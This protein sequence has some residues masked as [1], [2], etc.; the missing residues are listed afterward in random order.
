VRVTVVSE[1]Y[2]TEPVGKVDQPDFVN[3]TA[4]VE[5]GLSARR[6]LGICK[7]VE[8]AM[9]RGTGERWGPRV[10]DIDLL[11]LGEQIVEETDL[12]LPHPRMHERRFVLE[13]LADIAPDVVHPRLG[14]TVRGLLRRL[15]SGGGSVHKLLENKT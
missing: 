8:A 7:G 13:P 10:I 4:E 9:G 15:G 1:A 11:L 5:T 3:L 12:C 14:E 6:L 2:E